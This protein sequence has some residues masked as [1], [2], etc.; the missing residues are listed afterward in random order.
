MS[1]DVYQPDKAFN[2]TTLLA[3]NHLQGRSRIIEVDMLGRIVWEFPLPA[4][5]AAYTN[6][7]FD[8]EGLANGN[9]LFVL[10]LKGVYEIDRWG[11]EV[12]SYIDS[13]VSHDA[14]R[15]PNGN[16][17]VAFGGFDQRA[18]AQVK[19]IDPKGRVV[20]SWKAGEHFTDPAYRK[21]SNQG[22]T[23]TNAVSRLADG[24]TLISLRNFNFIAEVDAEGKVVNII[25]RGIFHEQHD[26]EVQPNGNILVM[27]HGRPH[28]AMEIDP[29][30]N[31]VVWQSRGFPKSMVPV[32]DADRLP[33]GNLLI[34]GTNKLLEYTPGGE[35]VWRL[36][37]NV[38]FSERREAPAFGF[39]K[40]E[41]LVRGQP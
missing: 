38:T 24:H 29:R 37:L 2:G 40:A 13:K 25:G 27:D 8:V 36:N 35:L 28:R 30:T 11:K 39:Y 32:R 34:T 21:I 23:H 18:D 20:W 22:W 15:L 14:D 4:G 19:E 41:R 9:I 5:L 33:N 6:P 26:P 31:R 7:G 17:L 1:V 3:D 16:T 12:W 10:P